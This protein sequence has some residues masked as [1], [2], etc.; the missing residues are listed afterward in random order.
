MACDCVFGPRDGVFLRR[1]TDWI[2]TE[3][4]GEGEPARNPSCGRLTAA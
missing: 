1:G 4:T 3:G 2:Y